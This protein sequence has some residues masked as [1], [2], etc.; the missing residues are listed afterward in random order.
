MKSRD[1]LCDMASFYEMSKKGNTNKILSKVNSI[2]ELEFNP[3]I[4]HVREEETSLNNESQKLV[5]AMKEFEALRKMLIFN[6]LQLYRLIN[7]FECSKVTHF[8]EYEV[9]KKV[10]YQWKNKKK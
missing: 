4:D 5:K 3:W 7:D 9:S 2:I 8:N 10:E 6:Y 1:I